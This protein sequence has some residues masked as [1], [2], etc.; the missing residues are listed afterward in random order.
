LEVI[1]ITVAKDRIM[2]ESPTT[3]F[4]ILAFLF[5]LEISCIHNVQDNELTADQ[6]SLVKIIEKKVTEKR[7]YEQFREKVL[8]R[9]FQDKI[10]N[11]YPVIRKYAKRYGID[12]RLVVVQIL[13]E[14]KFKENARSNVGAMGLMQIMPG[15][16]Q[17][18]R[19]E[20]DIEYIANN[21]RENITAGIYHLYKQLKNFPEADRDNRVKLALAAYNS[22]VGRI[23]DAQAIARNLSLD[24][25]SWEAV[26]EC[27]PKLTAKDWRLHL[28]VWE[29]GVP[30]YGYFYGYQQTI[31]YVD[32]IIRNY[33]IFR[34]VYSNL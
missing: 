8:P 21:P 24:P 19:R 14:S 6:D 23:Y 3:L 28:E 17:E 26:R 27:L 22:G 30:D 10:Q 1:G 20:M 29:L 32:D 34:T 33:Q 16:A 9:D 4:L 7:E 25:Q 31:D 13:K 2:K 5:S 11:Y 18:I 12:W 15:T